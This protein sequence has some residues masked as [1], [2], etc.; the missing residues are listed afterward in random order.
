MGRVDNEIFGL[1]QLIVTASDLKYFWYK[2]LDSLRNA[3]RL[4]HAG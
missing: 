2:M 4:D 3:N 1:R